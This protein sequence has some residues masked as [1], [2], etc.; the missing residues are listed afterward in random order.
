MDIEAKRRQRLIAIASI[1]FVLFAI[2]AVILAIIDAQK[3][4]KIDILVAPSSAKIKIDNTKFKT[5]GTSKYYPGEYTV[6][7][8]AQ[9][10][11][12]TETTIKL[13]KDQTTNL[14]LYLQP[15]SENQDFYKE[16][17]AE[18]TLVQRI[19]DLHSSLNTTQ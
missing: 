18:A 5:S 15:D 2:A 1:V 11:E 13:E 8:S 17:P 9:G 7:I 16:H 14:Y 10:F 12:T 19:N 3:T 6:V 4:A